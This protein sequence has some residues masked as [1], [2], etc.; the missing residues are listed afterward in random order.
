MDQ[1]TIKSQLD[2]SRNSTLNSLHGVLIK[3]ESIS[4]GDYPGRHIEFE[5]VALDNV[6]TEWSAYRGVRL[7][8]E[9]WRSR[10]PQYS[11]SSILAYSEC[12]EVFFVN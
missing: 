9:S 1:V 4:L 10:P 2:G 7:G 12:S 3:E 6:D 11:R 5:L 8:L